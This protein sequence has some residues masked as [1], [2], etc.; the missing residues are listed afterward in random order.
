M[1]RHDLRDGGPQAPA[2]AVA[3]DGKANLAARGEADPHEAADLLPGGARGTRSIDRGANR[4]GLAAQDL[5]DETGRDP[6]ATATR[7]PEKLRPALE[8]RQ[9][10]RPC[11]AHPS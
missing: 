2:R 9:R 5:E 10:A 8:M 3:G 1:S 6:F 4:R 7:D 11:P